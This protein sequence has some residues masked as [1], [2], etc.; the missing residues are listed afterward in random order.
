MLISFCDR[1][2]ELAE[3]KYGDR[4]RVYLLNNQPVLGHRT[5]CRV[6]ICKEPATHKVEA[7]P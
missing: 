1:H 7:K 5:L 3:W 2:R 6:S 4:V